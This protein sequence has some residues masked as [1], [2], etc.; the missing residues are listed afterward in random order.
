[1]N[2]DIRYLT[3]GLR[4]SSSDSALFSHRCKVFQDPRTSL[5]YLTFF[6]AMLWLPLPTAQRNKPERR[7]LLLVAL[8]SFALCPQ[9]FNSLF[10]AW[11]P[12]PQLCCN[13]CSDL[14]PDYPATWL[15]RHAHT[16]WVYIPHVCPCQTVWRVCSHDRPSPIFFCAKPCWNW[17]KLANITGAF[18]SLCFPYCKQSKAK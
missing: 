11:K 10:A 6:A 15:G 9:E 4:L 5:P 18:L 8:L 3:K 1:M 7:G 17:R 16:I 12:D 13:L 14:L 2:L